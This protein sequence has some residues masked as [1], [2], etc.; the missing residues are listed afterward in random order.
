MRLSCASR[1]MRIEKSQGMEMI[2]IS[3]GVLLV[4]TL[5][6]LW[7]ISLSVLLRTGI[8]TLVTAHAAVSSPFTGS[9]CGPIRTNNYGFATL[10]PHAVRLR[11]PL[12]HSSQQYFT[13]NG[14]I[15]MRIEQITCGESG[16][17]AGNSGIWKTAG[18][19]EWSPLES[20]LSMDS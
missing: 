13:T 2:I 20:L 10:N 18:I 1:L 4:I 7:P 11:C 3:L 15:N 9:K 19:G 5:A 8:W 17:S 16:F 14:A 6:L 12:S